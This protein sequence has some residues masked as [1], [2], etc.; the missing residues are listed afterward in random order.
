VTQAIP[1]MLELLPEGC[2]KAFGVEQLCLA[3]GIDPSTELLAIGDAENDAG[4]LRMACIGVAVGNASPPARDASDM[5][6]EFTNDQGGAGIAIELF[7]L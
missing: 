2:S 3:L 4:M 1:T 5:V 7:A 6:L